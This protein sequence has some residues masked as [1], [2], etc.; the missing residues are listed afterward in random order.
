MI[1]HFGGKT[2]VEAVRLAEALRGEGISAWLAFA[3]ERRSM[4]SQMRE[5][6]KR[7]VRYTLI[8]GENELENDEVAVRPMEKGK[9]QMVP[10]AELVTWLNFCSPVRSK[11]ARLSIDLKGWA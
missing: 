10:R 2:K 4:K 8:L 6:D 7:Q 3:R 11:K 9:Q 5:A 1:T